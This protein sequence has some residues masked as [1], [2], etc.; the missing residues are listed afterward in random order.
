MRGSGPLRGC[1]ILTEATPWKQ[2]DDH[3]SLALQAQQLIYKGGLCNSP[4]SRAEI[5]VC[6]FTKMCSGL[7]LDGH[8]DTVVPAEAG[9][10]GVRC[11][12]GTIRMTFWS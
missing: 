6:G 1:G 9:N 5:N 7:G 3:L 12:P 11:Q 10:P 2:G 8:P 4:R